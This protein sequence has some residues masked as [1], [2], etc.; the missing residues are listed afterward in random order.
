M[1]SDTSADG[2]VCVCG[3]VGR[4]ANKTKPLLQC[5]NHLMEDLCTRSR[6]EFKFIWYDLGQAASS[7]WVFI[8]FAIKWW[9]K[10]QLPK[11]VPACPHLQLWPPHK[12][13]PKLQFREPS[14]RWLLAILFRCSHVE[15]LLGHSPPWLYISIFLA[16]RVRFG[17][18]ASACHLVQARHPHRIPYQAQILVRLLGHSQWGHQSTVSWASWMCWPLSFWEGAQTI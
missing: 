8:S 10:P 2:C 1:F 16:S 18:L 7:L 12:S 11:L 4:G 3:G 13:S 17:D 9:Q 14:R 15:D 6:L 5:H